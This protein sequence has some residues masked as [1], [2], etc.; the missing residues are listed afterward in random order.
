M[1]VKEKELAPSKEIIYPPARDPKIIPIMIIDFLDM[2]VINESIKLYSRIFDIFQRIIIFNHE[3]NLFRSESKW[4]RLG[5][6][7]KPE[8][9]PFHF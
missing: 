2:V 7:V 5:P 9:R 1:E 8:N 4:F 3:C 6:R